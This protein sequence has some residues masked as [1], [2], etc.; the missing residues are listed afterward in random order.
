MMIDT[1][2]AVGWLGMILLILAYFFLSSKRLK[3]NSLIYHLLNLFGAV[4]IAVS[5]F[6]TKSWPSVTL[7]VIW[8]VIAGFSIYK[9]LNTKPVYKE[10]K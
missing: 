10:L 1:F 5:T 4:G 2:S 6:A 8:I 9:I 3:S 7:N